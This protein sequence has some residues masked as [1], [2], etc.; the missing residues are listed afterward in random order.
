MLGAWTALVALGVLSWHP[1]PAGAA[2]ASVTISPAPK[3]GSFT[4]GETVSVSVGPNS[5]FVPH[6]R[7]VI[8]EC[9][10]PSGTAAGLP[11][12]FNTCDGNTVQADS[13]IVKDDG[14]FS[15]KSYTMYALPNAALGEQGNWQPI[16]SPTHKCVL[17]VGEDQNDFSKPKVFSQAFSFTTTAVTQ[18]GGAASPTSTTVAAP[19]AAV[20][21]AVSLSP[22]TLAYTGGQA[23]AP[24]LVALGLGLF[25]FGAACTKVMRRWRR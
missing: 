25:A 16:C 1:G 19:T 4:T 5:L 17:F 22:A 14:S 7:I 18:S 15:E 3:A 12:S 2:S 9:A 6:S 21:A 23:V 10:D 24:W 20:S 13:V 11:T 8:I